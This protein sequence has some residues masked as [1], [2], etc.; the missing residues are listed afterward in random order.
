M[1]LVNPVITRPDITPD[2]VLVYAWTLADGDHGLAVRIPG[3]ADKSVQVLGNFG[4]SGNIQV[5]GTNNPAQASENAAFA[6]TDYS[7]LNDAQGNALDLAN[8]RIEQ[9]LENPY[10]IRPRVSAGTGVSVTVYLCVRR[11]K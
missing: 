4:T 10:W 9:I 1:A 7:L 6:S 2:D 5:Q 8:T 11:T 3:G